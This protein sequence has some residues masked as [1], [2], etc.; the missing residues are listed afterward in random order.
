V[1]YGYARQTFETGKALLI[2]R[3]LQ[4]RRREQLPP[5]AGCA[6]IDR[7][8][9]ERAHHAERALVKRLLWEGCTLWGYRVHDSLAASEWLRAQPRFAGL[10]T[11]TLG[12][13]MGSTMAVWVSALEPA[14]DACV[15]LCGLAEY[16]ALLARRMTCTA[17]A[18]RARTAARFQRPRSRR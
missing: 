17:S 3:P 7:V 11:A 14:I 6:A 16:D 15:E 2:G 4:V 8:F 10:P 9:G 5:W 18:F 12:L 13:S 1:L